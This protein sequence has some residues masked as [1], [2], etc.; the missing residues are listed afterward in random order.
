MRKWILAVASSCRRRPA[1]SPAPSGWTALPGRPTP[2][3]RSTPRSSIPPRSQFRRRVRDLAERRPERRPHRQGRRWLLR[4]GLHRPGRHLEAD[5]HAKAGDIAYTCERPPVQEGRRPREVA[6]LAWAARAPSVIMGPMG[7]SRM[8]KGMWSAA[9][10][11]ALVAGAVVSRGPSLQ[12]ADTRVDVGLEQT[13]Q[14]TFSRRRSRC[15]SAPRSS[16]STRPTSST[17]SR[18]RTARSTPR[19]PGQGQK[20]EFTFT[21]AGDLQVLLHAAQERRDEGRRERDAG[22]GTPTTAATTATTAGGHGHHRRCPGHR[23]PPRPRRRPGRR[24]RRRRGRAGRP[25]P[26]SPRQPP[27]R[28]PRSGRRRRPPRTTAAHPAAAR[29]RRRAITA[30]RSDQDGKEEEQPIGIAFASL[31]TVLLARSRESS[32]SL[33]V[34]TGAPGLR[35]LHFFLFP[36]SFVGFSR[37]V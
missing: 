13:S 14:L 22:A 16:G 27:R 21:K 8:R 24:R 20:Y 37:C 11:V 25:R 31:S 28:A 19:A 30:A 36:T 7:R 15:R 29:R 33:E 17:T 32:S 34:L 9:A 5:R 23:R 18:R 2:S 26:R 10:F 3:S 12:A 6:A 4:H 35:G 1:G